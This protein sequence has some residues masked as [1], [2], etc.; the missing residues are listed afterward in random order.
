MFNDFVDLM[1]PRPGRPAIN[2]TDD[3]V[4]VVRSFLTSKNE[5]LNDDKRLAFEKAVVQLRGDSAAILRSE[6]PSS[7]ASVS[8]SGP[9]AGP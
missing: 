2:V 6:P 7:A 9:S 8:G 3:I 5:G 4:I 1:D